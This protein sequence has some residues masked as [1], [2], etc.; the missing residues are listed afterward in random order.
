MNKSFNDFVKKIGYLK[1]GFQFLK[2]WIFLKHLLP[3]RHIKVEI[4]FVVAKFEV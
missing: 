4:R 3:F 2:N 1:T